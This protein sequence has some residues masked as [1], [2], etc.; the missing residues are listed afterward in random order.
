ML[1]MAKPDFD[2]AWR[3]YH[4]RILT[5]VARLARLSLEEAEDLTQEIFM[6]IYKAHESGNE[7]EQPGPG[8]YYAIARNHLVDQARK[9]GRR[10]QTV[11]LEPRLYRIES[12]QAGPEETLLRKEM[13]GRVEAYLK[14]LS[15]KDSEISFLKF[16]EGWTDQAI[17]RHLKTP[18]GTVK[19]RIH[20]MRRGL[21]KY[22]EDN[23]EA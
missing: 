9:Q 8:W 15:F 21:K 1:S 3:E 19:Y 12:P 6:K 13:A 2:A 11:S 18:S 7:P 5:Y 16:S 20:R 22:L 17:A 23:H 10:G 4:P 14:T